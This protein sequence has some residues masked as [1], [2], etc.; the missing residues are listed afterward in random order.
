MS[1]AIDDRR[2]DDRTGATVVSREHDTGPSHS[3]SPGSGQS[4]GDLRARCGLPERR[5]PLAGA[6][7]PAPSRTGQFLKGPVPLAWLRLAARLPGRALHLGLLIWFRSGLERNLKVRVP[8]A[9]LA[10]FGLDRDAK[11]R[12]LRG[13]E[14][15]GLVTVHR[16][17]GRP[18]DITL[19]PDPVLKNPNP[20]IIPNAGEQS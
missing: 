2:R 17:R 19:V 16:C 4:V 9:L 6:T 11:A 14:R 13:L 3:C 1:D 15:A 10:S 7:R 8:A 5:P 20:N 12:A 18:A